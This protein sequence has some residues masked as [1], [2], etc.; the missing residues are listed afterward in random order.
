M[1][2]L[3]A[4]SLVV[5]SFFACAEGSDNS[6]QK[7][8]GSVSP[9]DSGVPLL[10]DTSTTKTDG[11]V[12]P[13]GPP[14]VFGHSGDT[15]YKVDADTKQVTVIGQL[16]GCDGSLL[17]LAIDKDSNAVGVT[18][19]AMYKIN[20][21]TGACTQIGANGAP[22]PTSLTFVPAG[23][24]N[25]TR[26][27]LVGYG[28]Q[29]TSGATYYIEYDPSNGD[30]VWRSTNPVLPTGLESSGDIVSIINGPSYLTVK[31]TYKNGSKTVTCADCIVQVNP[32]TGEILKN[33]GP[34][35]Y[36]GVFGVAFWGGVVYGFDKAGDLFSIKFPTN[37]GTTLTV[38][39]IA[40][41][42]PPPKLS[43]F[44][45]GST[46]AAPTEGGR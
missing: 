6:F 31:G 25:A 26:E 30:E 45:A 40:I 34:F 33:F 9:D 43:F 37:G 13:S 28:G 38:T 16:T 20:L 39:D 12:L 14:Q 18:A 15:L 24:R 21:S 19:T 7:A 32:K 42:N 2:F 46:T 8:D 10:P 27:A 29:G 23:T 11:A 35:Q 4:T 3:A 41:P 44:G 17:D 5:T 22:Y 36:S 1:R